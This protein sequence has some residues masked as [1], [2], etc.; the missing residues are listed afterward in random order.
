MADNSFVIDLQEKHT[1][2]GSVK[3]AGKKVEFQALGM[4][5]TTPTFF[6]SDNPQVIQHQA[7]LLLQ[8]HQS[9][10]IKERIVNVVLPDAY[11]Y[12]QILQ[13]PMLKEKELLSA[14]RYQSDE[15]IPMPLEETNLD[16]EILSEDPKNKKLTVLIVAAPKKT[17]AQVEQTLELAG[18]TPGSLENELTAVGRFISEL[19]ATK[20]QNATLYVN[21]GDATTS[22][23]LMDGATSL[24]LFTRTIKMGL[25]IFI[26]DI[27]VNLNTDDVK[28]AEVLRTIGFAKSGSY[29]VDLMLAPVFK[30]F[31]AE[32][33]RSLAI[34]REHFA[35][36][37][38]AITL[39][40]YDN[41]IAHLDA[42]IAEVTHIP[43]T[44]LSLANV[45][46]PNPI[47]QSFAND[48][49]SVVSLIGGSL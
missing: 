18:F 3:I 29:D 16:I 44:S 5:D 8:M 47:S 20:K 9:L 11:T 31:V 27:K 6:T 4:K 23:Y 26:R 22:I 15:F 37:A 28:A 7:E 12:S 43:T 39:F 2:M 33:E 19:Y 34:A 30:M 41:R 14:I 42:K 46:V 40:N 13:M 1:R 45:L 24:I 21:I 49:S 10:K 36:Q 35:V 32:I 25:E 38:D 17:V 48:L